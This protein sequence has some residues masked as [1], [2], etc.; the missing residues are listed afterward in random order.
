[1]S[2]QNITLGVQ[3]DRFT[4]NTI[5]TET[6]N[7]IISFQRTNDF[8]IHSL[9]QFGDIQQLSLELTI[10]SIASA[11]VVPNAEVLFLIDVPSISSTV[12][13]GPPTDLDQAF[14]LQSL[15]ITTNVPNDANV[16]VSIG[17]QTITSTITFGDFDQP[18]PVH[19]SLIFKNDN[20]TKLGGADDVEIASGVVIQASSAKLTGNTVPGSAAGFVKVTID[21][22]DY[23]MPFFNL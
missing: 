8:A 1:M 4:A 22:V 21:G 7:T 17:T 13:F 20:I 9:L 2:N 12:T 5:N 23:K 10:P 14:D 11:S 3:I 15:S 18:R 16:F 6:S 19:R